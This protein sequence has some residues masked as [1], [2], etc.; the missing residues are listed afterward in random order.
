MRR[1]SLITRNIS[2]PYIRLRRSRDPP[3]A[4]PHVPLEALIVMDARRAI[5]IP[6]NQVLDTTGKSDLGIRAV[7]DKERAAGP[8]LRRGLVVVVPRLVTSA[9]GN[10]LIEPGRY[11]PAIEPPAHKRLV[12]SRRLIGHRDFLLLRGCIRQRF[13]DDDIRVCVSPIPI[14][15]TAQATS[16]SGRVRLF[17]V[18][19]PR[20]PL[21]A[22]KANLRHGFYRRQRHTPAH[23]LLCAT[24]RTLASGHSKNMRRGTDGASLRP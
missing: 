19:L 4:V 20:P 14:D 17:R 22:D 11:D 13:R 16:W 7:R 21:A 3:K 2:E 10:G 23:A 12:P 15:H 18:R 1:R 6:G 24:S 9:V 8:L 5:L